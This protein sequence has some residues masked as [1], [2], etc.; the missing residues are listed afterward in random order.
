MTG[1][2]SLRISSMTT[3]QAE[4]IRR[5]LTLYRRVLGGG[6]GPVC[7]AQEAGDWMHIPRGWYLKVG[8]QFPFLQQM[9]LKEGRADG[10]QLP[11]GTRSTMVLGQPPFPESQKGFVSD[12]V[13]GSQATGIGGRVGAPTRYGK[14][15]CAISAAIQLGG[16]TLALT[17]SAMVADQW[18][19]TWNRW[20]VDGAGLSIPAGRIQ[21]D[22]L[23]LPPQ[24]PFVVGMMQTLLRRPLSEEARSAF[25]TIILD[26]ADCAPTDTA[27]AALQRFRARYVLGLSATPD[28]KDGLG[29]AIE[30]ICGPCVAEA[31]RPLEGDV[32]FAHIPW[33]GCQVPTRSGDK[34]RGPRLNR[35]GGGTDIVEAEKALLRDEERVDFIGREAQRGGES[36]RHG[37]VLVG[38]RDHAIAIARAARRHGMDPGI[39][40]GG[41]D[42]HERERA[43][44][45]NPC[46][47]TLGACAKGGNFEP[48]PNLCIIAAP[49]AD[50]RQAMGRA[51]QPQATMRTTILDLV[52]GHP[53]LIKMA[54]ARL[55]GS[56]RIHPGFK[57]LSEV[58]PHGR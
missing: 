50:V 13:R 32:W 55:K 19:D 56:Y 9:L 35:P 24:Y 58:W 47:A 44:Q 38:L 26:E 46:I 2:V 21:R 7:F 29:K 41:Q 20:V 14:T 33:R 34:M 11:P 3:M 53:R 5:E 37:L 12:I 10:Q 23:D 25:R 6:S 18:A 43:M 15:G 40:Q 16:S 36:G 48:A 45:H 42:R 17:N 22:R 1:V 49:R 28:R 54:N 30:W 51:F 8:G 52:D 4:T 39:L 31:S 57:I 27:M